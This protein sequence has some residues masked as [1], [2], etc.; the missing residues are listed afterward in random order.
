MK[1]TLSGG[2][3]SSRR[4]GVRQRIS[5]QDEQNR[6]PS[7]SALCDLILSLFAWG[8]ISAQ[9]AQQLAEAAYAD[10]AK[11]Q[12]GETDLKNL[13]KIGA[14]GCKGAYPNKCYGD[15]MK[16]IPYNIGIPQGITCS[17]PFKTG[18]NNLWQTFLL[19][20]TMFAALWSQYQ[21]I[22]SSSILPC[23]ARLRDFWKINRSHPAMS[24]NPLAAR[25][26]LE[27]RVIP[28]SFH[29]DDVP[30]TGVG[31]SWCSQMTVF[32]W[33]S[34]VGSGTTRTSQF[35][36]YG[37][38][39]KLRRIDPDQNNDTLGRFFRILTWSLTWLARGQWPDR[40]WDGTL[41]LGTE[42]YDSETFDTIVI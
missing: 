8:T 31:K 10:A 24:G 41:Y 39:D 32:S 14:I 12:A 2:A 9:L 19:P 4:G 40:H 21:C 6:L 1:R 7:D 3:S 16:C 33:S 37:V 36:I 15:I 38:F 18:L 35:F 29:G 11:M 5:R 25:A 17:L 23:A 13:K 42:F 20:H 28:I 27:T 34:M 30:I 26:D 22:W